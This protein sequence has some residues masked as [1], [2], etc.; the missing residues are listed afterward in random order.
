MP[1]L[2]ATLVK[3]AIMTVTLIHSSALKLPQ[4]R[5][6]FSTRKGGVSQKPY[7]SLNLGLNLGDQPEAVQ[8]NLHRFVQAAEFGPLHQ[9]AE[10]QQV[11]GTNVVRATS[12]ATANGTL[13]AIKADA[14]WT[15]EPE[16]AVAVRTADCSPILLAVMDQHR[17][18]AV[19]AIH[20]GWRSA[21]GGI[22]NKTISTLREEGF[23]TEQMY[24]AIGPTIGPLA[25]E[26]GEE[27]ISAARASL[28][29]Q[30][31]QTEP[32]LR[33]RPHLNLP[34]LVS[35]Q[36]I[37]AGMRADHIHD[38]AR[39]TASEPEFFFSHRRDQGRS[40]RHLSAIQI[41]K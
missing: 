15:S 14:I 31:P 12:S 30:A 27:V 9:L 5:H 24:A 16:V 13:A 41:I 39:C 28:D 7:K 21:C 32:G 38:V 2:G 37:N 4:I 35:K 3:D 25:F 19:A 26:V 34:D 33:G 36:L 29:G 11:H 22:I 23:S 20:A 8:E 10:V 6:A 40:G 1:P 17:P 18:Q